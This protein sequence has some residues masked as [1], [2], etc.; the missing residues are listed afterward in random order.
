MSIRHGEAVTRPSEVESTYAWL[1]LAASVLIG[2]VGNIGM[3]AVVVVL[4]AVEAEFGVAR[5]GASLPYTITLLAFAGGGI[6]TGRLADRYGV[7]LPV[8]G[9][10]ILL[11]LGYV[12]TSRAD[13]ILQFAII[14]GLLIGIGSSGTFGPLLADI[15]HWFTRHRGFAVAICASGNY[16][17]GTVWPP[18]IHH[19]AATYGWRETF[20][21]LGLFCL[22]TLLPLALITLRRPSPHQQIS[23]AE[24][25]AAGSQARLGIS[26]NV[27]LG[28][29]VVAGVSCCVAMSM[30]QVHIVAY[31]GD[32]GYG[33]ARG[34]EMLS[35]ML[36]FGI[37]SRLISGWIVDRIG[38]LATLLLG[39]TLQAIALFL[40]LPFTSLP[41][42]YVISALFGLFQGGI[43]PSY[44]IVV[45][46]YFAPEEAG[47]RVGVVLMATLIGMA[48]GGWLSGALYDLTGNYQAAFING[49]LWNVLNIAI[50]GWL[51]LRKR[52]QSTVVA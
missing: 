49:I 11:G 2:T 19:F 46:E 18:L 5:A 36:G 17:A 8:V 35:L 10:A 39:S 32:L 20:F 7:I 47:T 43:V 23:E 24:L 25:V 15:S 42:L 50:V 40:Y 4:P 12:L 33:A 52:A 27:L 28:L 41:S 29:L 26:P 34:A 51:L 16:L 31:C 21:G 13:S 48:L 22:M 3:W 37:I 38:G 45:R 6:F 30:P 9:A 14:H 1:R 44:A